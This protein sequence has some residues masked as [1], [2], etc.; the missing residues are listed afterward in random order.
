MRMK[1]FVKG[2]K[3]LFYCLAFLAL[4]LTGLF[5]YSLLRTERLLAGVDQLLQRGDFAAADAK[6]ARESQTLL[7]K[8][9]ERFFRL[10]DGRL[11]L[12]RCRV[13]FELAH[14]DETARFCQSALSEAKTDEERFFAYWYLA[15]AKLNASITAE[16]SGGGGSDAIHYLEEALKLKSDGEA[17]VLLYLLLE[18]RAKF[19][20]MLK[21]KKQGQ[22]DQKP[23]LPSLFRDDNGGTGAAKEKGY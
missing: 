22:T 4:A 1:W 2:L 3:R 8:A 20:E 19:N 18:E 17:Q 16:A 11:A 23:R 12:A 5:G 10:R 6:L 15:L 13:S 21:Q 7:Y 14:L 9:R